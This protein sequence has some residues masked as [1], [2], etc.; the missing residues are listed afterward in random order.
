M[1]HPTIRF[2][3]KTPPSRDV[4]F[5]RA[6]QPSVLDAVKA[7]YPKLSASLVQRDLEIELPEGLFATALLILSG[8]SL[9]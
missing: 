2:S 7:V 1:I 3:L 8:I 6:S 9:G 4:G 5:I